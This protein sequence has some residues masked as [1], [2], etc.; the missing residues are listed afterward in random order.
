MFE[1]PPCCLNLLVFHPARHPGTVT[2]CHDCELASMSMGTWEL[3]E[4]IRVE[5]CRTH[6]SFVRLLWKN[7]RTLEESGYPSLE[8]GHTGSI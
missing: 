4:G 7:G 1:S 8:D 5:H 6:S 2:L 3:E